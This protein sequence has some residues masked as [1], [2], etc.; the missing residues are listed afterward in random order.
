MSSMTRAMIAADH[1]AQLAW[2]PA[3]GADG[4]VAKLAA[5]RSCSRRCTGAAPARSCYA[6]GRCCARFRNSPRRDCPANKRCQCCA[7][8]RLSCG[9]SAFDQSLKAGLRRDMLVEAIQYCRQFRLDDLPEVV[10]QTGV[11]C[12][13]AHETHSFAQIGGPV[14]NHVLVLQDQRDASPAETGGV[15]GAATLVRKPSIFGKASPAREIAQELLLWSPC[16]R[17][18]VGAPLSAAKVRRSASAR[19]NRRGQ[20]RHAVPRR[21]EEATAGASAAVP[22]FSAGI[23]DGQACQPARQRATRDRTRGWFPRHSSRPA[24]TRAPP[25]CCARS[26]SN[27]SRPANRSAAARCPACCR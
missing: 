8:I 23:D 2:R 21:A 6:P 14:R 17:K 10:Q 13:D 16:G 7:W 11:V 24:S 15:A 3:I 25:R 9:N 26:S 4:D 18:L 12:A 27:M 20:D 5:G 1:R 22:R 19:G